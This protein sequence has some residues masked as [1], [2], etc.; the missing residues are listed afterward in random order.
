MEQA[1][2]GRGRGGP[3]TRAPG[4]DS[5]PEH[6]PVTARQALEEIYRREHGALLAYLRRRVGPDAAAD[7]VQET[8]LRAASSPQLGCLANPRA[9]LYRIARNI[10]IDRAR[11]K[12]RQAITVALGDCSTPCGSDQQREIEARELAAVLDGALAGLPQK[13]RRVFAMSRFED[14]TYREIHLDLGIS[15]ATVEY[16]MMKA[17]SHM[18]QAAEAAS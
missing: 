17:L 18:R 13:T 4:T 16:H 10:L 12:Q 6:S 7:L 15:V 2:A 3:P 1:S 11:R 8:F 9:F 14:R 5:L